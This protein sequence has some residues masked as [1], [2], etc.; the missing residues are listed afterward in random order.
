ML[1]NWA[2]QLGIPVLEVCFPVLRA[3]LAMWKDYKISQM[4]FS[5]PL[6]NFVQKKDGTL[7]CFNALT[8]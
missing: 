3:H 6:I 2:S 5:S 4:E 1:H 8:K 7:Q